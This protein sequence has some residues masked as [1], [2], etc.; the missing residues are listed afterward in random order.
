MFL[1]SVRRKDKLEIVV[2]DSQGR[3]KTT[4]YKSGRLEFIPNELYIS[5][6]NKEFISPNKWKIPFLFGRY[7]LDKKETSNGN[8]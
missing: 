4:R 6:I 7:R 5:L 1:E 8:N 3:I 2:R